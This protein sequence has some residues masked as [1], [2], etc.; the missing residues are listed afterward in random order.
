MIRSRNWVGWL[1]RH[2]PIVTSQKAV[3]C[4]GWDKSISD[5]RRDICISWNQHQ[6]HPRNFGTRQEPR[7]CNKPTSNWPYQGCKI[8]YLVPR[9][10][11]YLPAYCCHTMTIEHMLLQ[12]TVLQPSR[13]HSWVILEPLW[14]DPQDLRNRVL[15]K[16]DYCIWDN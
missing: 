9:V 14:D 11:D 10:V 7:S 16:L 13:L 6:G 8:T 15:E 1:W 3:S 12:C 4:L 2:W 5:T